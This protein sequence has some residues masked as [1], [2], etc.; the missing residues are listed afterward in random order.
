MTKR[1][2]LTATYIKNLKPV[3]KLTKHFDGEGLYLLQ[4]PTGKSV[5]KVAYRWNG[6]ENTKTLGD[7]R[8]VSLA[9]AREQLLEVRKLV[10]RGVDPNKHAKR[11]ERHAALVAANTVASVADTYFKTRIGQVSEKTQKAEKNL[12]N[13]HAEKVLGGLAISEVSPFDVSELVKSTATKVSPGQ[14]IALQKVLDAIFRY[15]QVSGLCKDNPA[16]VTAGVIKPPKTRHYAAV[17]TASAFADVLQRLW[18]YDKNQS[19]KYYLRCL[20][21][22]CSRPGELLAMKWSELTLEGD[23]PQWNYLVGKVQKE[24][25]VPL[26]DS[27]VTALKELRPLTEP[28]GE[29]VFGGRKPGRPVSSQAVDDAM[30]EVGIPRSTQTSHG[31]RATFRTIGQGRKYPK[32]PMEVILSHRIP[33]DPNNG[34]YNRYIYFDERKEILRDWESYCASLRAVQ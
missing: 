5:W 20:P 13:A 10:L 12:F 4:Y 3:E 6:K 8:L 21:L 18:S 14:A 19:I 2:G 22:I 7:V 32:D 23:T 30:V 16:E 33:D 9:E 26:V 28:Y 29:Y 27:V 17:T 34:A 25:A 11:L 1:H 31:F 15:G 24:V